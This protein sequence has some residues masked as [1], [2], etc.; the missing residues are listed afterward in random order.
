MY[1]PIYPGNINSCST[2]PNPL[3]P[4]LRKT[5]VKLTAQGPQGQ[6]KNY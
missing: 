5:E 1:L 6:E 4:V 3:V 2:N